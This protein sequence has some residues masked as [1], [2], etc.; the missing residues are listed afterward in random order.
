VPSIIVEYADLAI[1]SIIITFLMLAMVKY[2]HYQFSFRS[3]N[4]LSL[5]P[6]LWAILSIV[7]VLIR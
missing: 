6:L 2:C 4:K 7:M 3:I 5:R 1:F